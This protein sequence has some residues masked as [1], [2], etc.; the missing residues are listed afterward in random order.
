MSKNV[1][2]YCRV[3]SDEQKTERLSL[4][5]QERALRAYCESNGYH[6]VGDKQPYRED[7]SAKHF[8]LQ[9]PE[10]KSIYEYCRR[11]VGKVDLVLFLRWDRYSRNVEF[12]FTYKRLFKDELGVEINALEEPIDFT[13]TDWPM[14]LS[15]RCGVAHT[16]DLKIARRTKEGIHEHLMRGEWCGKA[17]RGYKNVKANEEAGTD[18]YIAID[19]QMA[20]VIKQ[21]FE[22]V[23]EGTEDPM[24]IKRRLMPEASKTSY[25]K[26]LRNPFYIGFLNVPAFRDFPSCKVRGKHEPLIDEATFLAVQDVMDGKRKK[27]PKMGKANNPNLFLRKFLSCPVC[28][29]RL[30]GAT[31]RG[32]GGRYDYYCCNHDHKHLNV[33]AENANKMFIQYI[34]GLVPNKAVS[35]LYKEILADARGT[36]RQARKGEISRLQGKIQVF[37]ERVNKVNDLYFDGELSKADRDE[38]VQR[39]KGNIQ[40]I[41]TQ[42]KALQASEEEHIKD[43]VEYGVNIVENLTTYFTSAS[44]ETKIRLLGSIFNE[45]IQFD[46]ENYRTSNFNSML[47]FIYQNSSELQGK[48]EADSPVFS[49]KSALVARRGIEPLFKV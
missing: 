36:V 46:G 19:Q 24:S 47:G 48:T 18:H 45:E 28:G 20:P 7:Y 5:H 4:E 6:I 49:G 29:H 26:M 39:Y 42:I 15:I 27:K 40:S 22:R 41:E 11:N 17:P 35:A 37:K 44:A 12:A 8:D 43:K 14:W 30:T 3:S 2:L 21:V 9:R 34:A 23:A 32:H 31:T 38:Q 13:A 16:E 25:F 10:I 33:R 1:I